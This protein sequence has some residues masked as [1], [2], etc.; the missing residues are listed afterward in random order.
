MMDRIEESS[1][2]DEN[3]FRNDF[4]FEVDTPIESTVTDAYKQIEAQAKGK[5]RGTVDEK[6]QHRIKVLGIKP[7]IQEAESESYDS[8]EESGEEFDMEKNTRDFIL[9]PARKNKKS[10]FF[11]DAP[12]LPDATDF[13]SLNI[14]RPILKGITELGWKEPTPI[15]KQAIPI[16]LMGRDIAGSA[17]TGSGKTGAF[18]LPILERLLYRDTSMPL[19]RVLIVTPTRELALQCAEVFEH[20]SSYANSIKVCLVLGG[21]SLNKQTVDLRARPDIIVA[22]PGRLLDHLLN[23]KAFGLEDLEILVLDEADRLLEL[24]FAESVEEIVRACPKNRHTMLYSATMTSKVTDLMKLCLDRPIRISVD[25]MYQTSQ[26]LVQEFIRIRDAND[27]MRESYLI[28]I[29]TRIYKKQVIIFCQQ[30]VHAHRLKIVFALTGLKAGELHGNL[31]QLQRIDSMESFKN[32]EVDYLLCTDLASRGLD[33]QGVQTVINYTMPNSQEIYI[34]RVGRTA[35][36]GKNGRAVSLV[37]DNDRGLLKKIIKNSASGC[38]HRVVPKKNVKEWKDRIGELEIDIE[39]ILVEEYEERLMRRTMMEAEKT[40]NLIKHEKDIHARPARTWFQSEQEKQEINERSRIRR[41]GLE[42][43]VQE[44]PTKEERK[45]LRVI[46]V[47]ER[48]MGRREKILRDVDRLSKV[49]R[50]IARKGSV[51]VRQKQKNKKRKISEL[52]IDEAPAKKI[53]KGGKKSGFKSKKRYKRR[54]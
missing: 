45:N 21:L 30:K 25:P 28:D 51:Q 6:I 47:I 52:D 13:A 48:P 5:G 46:P 8:S 18:A 3:I 36:A 16:A 49:D 39:A 4:T 31:T 1:S 17:A 26:R 7:I 10:S 54:R 41:L 19:T 34:H 44:E 29:C 38:K 53:R 50:K 24:G 33:I 43:E 42:E 35:R 11:H 9:K 20:L 37:S 2:E 27:A 40:T 14:S 15:Q 23:T 12:V 32:K 22:T